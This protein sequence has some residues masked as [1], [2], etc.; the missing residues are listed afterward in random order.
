MTAAGFILFAA[1][2]NKSFILFIYFQVLVFDGFCQIS[3]QL[4]GKHQLVPKISPAKT[5]EGLIGGWLC[6]LVAAMMASD[7]VP[8]DRQNALLFG[9]LTGLTC[10]IGDLLASWY[11]RKVKVKDYSNW[12]PGQGGFLDRFDSFLCTASVYYLLFITIFNNGFAFVNKP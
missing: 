5:V 11:K 12:L 8:F 2:F 4:F 1:A 7:W 9:L 10:L 3:G 6:C